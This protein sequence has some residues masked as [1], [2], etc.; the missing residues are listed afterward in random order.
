MKLPIACVHCCRLPEEHA[1]GRQCL[2]QPT[3]Y[4]PLTK[5]NYTPKHYIRLR[6][7]L[8]NIMQAALTGPTDIPLHNRRVKALQY[9]DKACTHPNLGWPHSHYQDQD[10]MFCGIC[11][12]FL[13]KA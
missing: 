5:E 11:H 1:G 4:L 7:A 6:E 8:T 2:F 3:Q 9:L 12:K 13:R 10:K